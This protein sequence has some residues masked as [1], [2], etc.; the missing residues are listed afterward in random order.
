MWRRTLLILLCMIIPW[1]SVKAAGGFVTHA[2]DMAISAVEHLNA[3]DHHLAHHHDTHDGG[4]HYDHSQDSTEHVNDH[5]VCSTG[6]LIPLSLDVALFV[7]DAQAPPEW[8]ARLLPAPV[9]EK[10]PRPPRHTS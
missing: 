9:L 1:Q 7:P 5:C 10:L 2:D 3:H 4:V 8:V 6:W